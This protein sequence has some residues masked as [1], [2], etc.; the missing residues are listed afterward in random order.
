[1]CVVLRLLKINDWML[2]SS[3]SWHVQK[4][5]F[6]SK[7]N[8]RFISDVCSGGVFFL[9]NIVIKGR[10]CVSETTMEEVCATENEIAFCLRLAEFN[11]ILKKVCWLF[12]KLFLQFA[13]SRS[14]L[15]IFHNPYLL[16]SW[17][18]ESTPMFLMKCFQ[19]YWFTT[20]VYWSN[21]F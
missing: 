17:K 5:T 14:L 2:S 9:F 1:M 12:C 13:T 21:L 3:V 8:A 10:T 4:N 11:M 15:E 20:D 16:V 6:W 7:P 18:N 19:G